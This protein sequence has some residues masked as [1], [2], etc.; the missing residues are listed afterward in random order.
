[1]LQVEHVLRVLSQHS[2]VDVEVRA[3]GVGHVLEALLPY[4]I[5]LI[6]DRKVRNWHH[7]GVDEAALTQGGEGNLCHLAQCR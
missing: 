3:L 1:V 7:S 5:P 4:S 6:T 2:H